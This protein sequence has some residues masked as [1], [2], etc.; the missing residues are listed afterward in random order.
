MSLVRSAKENVS[1]VQCT[2]GVYFLTQMERTKVG[3]RRLVF[4]SFYFL[5]I[6]KD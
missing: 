6:H 1:D 4:T 2:A 3:Y 5:K